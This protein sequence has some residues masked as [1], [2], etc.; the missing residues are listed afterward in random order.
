MIAIAITDQEIGLFQRLICKI[1]GI[2]HF[3]HGSNHSTG[4]H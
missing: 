1:A 3:Y 4:G 2:S